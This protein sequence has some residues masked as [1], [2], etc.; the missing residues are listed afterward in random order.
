M[1]SCGSRS[2]TAAALC[3]VLLGG[4]AAAQE[5]DDLLVRMRRA[6][7]D[8]G[9]VFLERSTTYRIERSKEGF[10]AQ[11]TMEERELMLKDQSGNSQDRS[12][13]YSTLIPLTELE[14]YTLVPAGK[15]RRK[16]PVQ[17]IDHLDTRGDNVFHDDS[18]QASFM[19]PS[20]VSG[21]IAVVDHTITYPD[22]RLMTG[23]FFAAHRPVE[24]SRMT[25]IC[26]PALEVDVRTFHLADS[27][28]ERTVAMEKGKRV[29]R[30]VM[31]RVP[32]LPYEDNA[33]GLRYYA[34]HAELIVRPSGTDPRD[35]LDRMYAWYSTFVKDCYG[36]PGAEMQALSDSIVGGATEGTDKAARIYKWVQDHVHYVAFEDGMNGL[37][38]APAD[39]VHKAGYGD[40]K[41]MSNLLY[42]LLRA[43]GLRAHLTW[44]GTRDL[45][46]RYT[47]LANSDCD[48]HMIVALD[49]A[50][51]T[52]FLD[53]TAGMN[54]FGVPSGFTQ[55]KE[56]LIAISA[57]D[58]AVKEIPVMPASFSTLVDSVRVRIDGTALTGTG[59]F[60]ATGYDRYMIARWLSGTTG[61]KRDALIRSLLMKGSNKFM[62][63]SAT[64]SGLDDAAAPLT[65]RYGFRIPDQ[66]RTTNGRSYVPLTLSD[67]WEGQHYNKDRKLPIEIDHC[68]ER[69]Y[70]V[71]LDLPPGATCRDLPV[72]RSVEEE[73]FGYA[74]SIAGDDRSVTSTASFRVNKLLLDAERPAWEGMNRSLLSE[75]GR[76]LVIDTP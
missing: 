43:Q 45:P 73:A 2:R 69:H 32:A 21:A 3:L 66:V 6:W 36:T 5:A 13:S 9:S 38:P 24:E 47:E 15:G 49:L 41:G 55:G 53:G 19:M 42:E 54:A 56:A 51:T 23:H 35:D 48:N 27:L 11:R 62:V 26:D 31:H 10:V 37:V 59:T 64:V 52:Y 44:V 20:L 8:H 57:G 58:H 68:Y 72:E 33:P 7:P 12:V 75:L 40:C 67:P 65:I 28:V 70:V 22:H 29:V 63:D 14:A 34:P 30:L 76:V 50:D 16:V 46:Y 4:S 74:V 61:P 18:R 71:H 25:I 17:A 1:T 39:Q 60:R